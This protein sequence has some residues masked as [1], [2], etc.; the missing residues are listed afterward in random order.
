MCIGLNNNNNDCNQPI[1]SLDNEPW[2][3][4]PKK[5]SKP[6]NNIPYMRLIICLTDEGVP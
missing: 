6:N 2:T 3:L 5:S 4:L 1:F